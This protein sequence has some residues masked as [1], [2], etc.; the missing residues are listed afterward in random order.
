MN[1]DPFVLPFTIGLIYLVVILLWRYFKWLD[2]LEVKDRYKFIK[3]IFSLNLFKAI[4]DVFSESLF[5]RKI[6]KINFFLGFM[7]MSFALFWFLMIIVGSLESKLVSKYPFNAP[8]DPIFLKYFEHDFSNVSTHT[9]YFF[10]M[11][12]FLLLLL[13]AVLLAVFK[14]LHSSVFGLKK[15]T[16]HRLVD[17]IARYLLWLIFPLRYIAESITSGLYQNGGFLTG[18]TG[19]ILA[20]S[21]SSGLLTSI[22]YPTWWLYSSVLGAFFAIMPF[23]RYMHIPTEVVLIFLRRFGIKNKNEIKGFANFEIQACS[24]CGICIDICQMYNDAQMNGQQAVYYLQHLRFKRNDEES[25]YNCLMCLRCN[26]YCP[27]GIDI[28]HLR[29]LKRNQL[30]PKLAMDI[31]YLHNSPKINTEDIPN[32]MYYAGCMTH[33]RPGTIHAFEAILKE[34]KVNYVFIDKE[35]TICCGRP[36]FLAGAKDEAMKLVQKNTELFQSIGSKLLVTSC[37][38]CL[39][40]FKEEYKIDIHVIHHTEFLTMLLK[41]NRLQL[42]QSKK[43]FVYHDPCELGRGLNEF[44]NSRQI[45]KEIGKSDKINLQ[46]N[47]SLCCGGSLATVKISAEQRYKITQAAYNE[48][49]KNK[50]D[51]LIT[52][53]PR[54]EHTFSTAANNKVL[55]IAEFVFENMNFKNPEKAEKH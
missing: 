50:P 37:P 47:K 26:Y 3:G 15:T 14:K 8:Y 21:F 33:L 5:H 23:S 40:M 41:S 9:L 36:L 2:E 16:N 46:K 38:I 22:E 42:N 35:L 45:L 4:R 52:S 43:T 7:H 34:C 17:K 55:D 53:C 13:I 1:F 19:N 39:K 51:C 12:L 54:C 44:K 25:I 20:N 18:S 24:S 27:V 6:F 28:S 48:L 10:S 31:D 11:D 32:V 29:Q 30:M 49:T